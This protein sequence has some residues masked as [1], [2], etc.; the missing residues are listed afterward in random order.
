M[1]AG[2]LIYKCYSM[3]NREVNQTEIGSDGSPQA[4]RDC[5]PLVE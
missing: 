5:R 3:G 4:E 2:S 1:I